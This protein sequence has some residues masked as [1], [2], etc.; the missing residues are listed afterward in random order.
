MQQDIL[1]F[2][3]RDFTFLLILITCIFF[4]FKS[5]IHSSSLLLSLSD[6]LHVSIHTYTHFWTSCLDI[7]TDKFQVLSSAAGLKSYHSLMSL[8]VR[9]EICTQ[10]ITETALARPLL[11]S[12]S[13]GIIT[14]YDNID[15]VLLKMLYCYFLC[16]LHIHFP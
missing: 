2:P 13:R 3:L 6:S 4:F 12:K 8:P 7:F 1:H 9:S 10:Y 5:P 14:A 15:H 16:T 11:C